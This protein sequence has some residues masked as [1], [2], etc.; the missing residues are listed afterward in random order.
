MIHTGLDAM[1]AGGFGQG[2]CMDCIIIIHETVSVKIQWSLVSHRLSKHGVRLTASEDCGRSQTSTGVI[3]NHVRLPVWHPCHSAW[4][5]K[6]QTVKWLFVTCQAILF[7]ALKLVNRVQTKHWKWF[8]PTFQTFYVCFPGL[9]RTTYV[10]FR[11]LF[12]PVVIKQVR[13]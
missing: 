6:Q 4:S 2:P 11:W 10:H 3:T 1:Y 5:H 7:R 12:N 13:F 9:S 8:S